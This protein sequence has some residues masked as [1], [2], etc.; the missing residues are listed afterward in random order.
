MVETSKQICPECKQE[1][2]VL[3]VRCTNC[4]AHLDTT[5]SGIDIRAELQKQLAKQ[6]E[7]TVYPVIESPISEEEADDV[8]THDTLD[9]N[10]P[11][12]GELI[13]T[14]KMGGALA[15]GGIVLH[16]KNVGKSFYINEEDLREV[17]IGRVN[18]ST[19]YTPTID[20]SIVKGREL[21]VSRRHAT[22]RRE[23][24]ILWLVDHS[25]VN[26]TFLNGVKLVPEQKRIVRENDIIRFGGIELQI[27]YVQVKEELKK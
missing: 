11:T 10:L 5:L 23:N 22:L 9:L 21:G 7:P 19:R 24:S 2:D 6:D 15:S 13:D 27:I 4:D 1:N 17:L 16:V 8:P 26:G 3:V 20:L 18:R 25:S 14:S 12:T